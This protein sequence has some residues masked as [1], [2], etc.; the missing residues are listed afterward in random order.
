[1]SWFVSDPMKYRHALIEIPKQRDRGAAIVATSVLEEH[2]LEAIQSKLDRHDPVE[3][4]VFSGYGPLA[5]F[6]SRIDMG[7]LLGLYSVGHHKRMH[8]IRRIRN[9]FAHSMHPISFKSQ[10][11]D[12]SKLVSSRTY[13]EMNKVFDA[14]TTPEQPQIRLSMFRS[15]TNPRTQFLRGVQLACMVLCIQIIL[16]K[17]DKG[18]EVSGKLSQV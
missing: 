5:T 18:Q 17:R 15:S 12:C 10:S 6:S 3:K 4:K 2:L 8:L 1:M 11:A 9:N 14:I 13:R 16:N 7:L